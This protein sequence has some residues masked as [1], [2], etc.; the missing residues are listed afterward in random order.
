MPVAPEEPEAEVVCAAGLLQVDQEEPED[1]KNSAGLEVVT[2]A[3]EDEDVV[4][5]PQ[6]LGDSVV[7]GATLVEEHTPGS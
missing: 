3:A 6:V 5:D 1:W 7:E 4:V 2:A